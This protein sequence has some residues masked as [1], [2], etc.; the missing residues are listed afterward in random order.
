M[1]PDLLRELYAGAYSRLVGQLYG[2]CGDLA[3]A[4]DVVAEAFARGVARRRA[5]QAAE[6]PEAW[7]R[8]VAVNVARSRWRRR[9]VATRLTALRAQTPPQVPASHPDLSTDRIALVQALRR[10][11]PS[12]R[13]AIALH[14]FADLPVHE[15]AHTLQVPV[16][17]VKARLSRGRAALAVLLAE[18]NLDGQEGVRPVV[19]PPETP[20]GSPAVK[21]AT[22]A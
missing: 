13:E 7:L 20:K 3:E 19:D 9:K 8:T 17:T 18:S 12:Q 1:E 11:S 10:I 2:I 14:Y 16:G 5:L 15:V 4:E 21:G 6:N 22:H